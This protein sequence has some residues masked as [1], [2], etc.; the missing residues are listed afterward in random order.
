MTNFAF[1][2]RLDVLC[3]DTDGM[4]IKAKSIAAVVTGFRLCDDT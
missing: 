4:K 3:Y 2:Q 1:N